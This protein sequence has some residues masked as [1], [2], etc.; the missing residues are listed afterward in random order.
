MKFWKTYFWLMVLITVLA[1]ISDGQIKP[2]DTLDLIIIVTGLVGLF[3]YAYK[4]RLAAKSLWQY[5]TVLIITY[6]FVYSFFLDQ[7]FGG[8]PA[9][10]LGDALF[11]ALLPLPIFVALI[12]Y[13][14]KTQ[15]D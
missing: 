6:H 11:T 12:L 15:H 4:R 7:K 2:V 8:T 5:L 14:F 3:C 10:G 9:I 1:V 13:S